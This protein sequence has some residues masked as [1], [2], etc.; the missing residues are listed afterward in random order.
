VRKS[1]QAKVAT[2]VRKKTGT[3]GKST[4]AKRRET[5][6]RKTEAKAAAPDI[7]K[8]PRAQTKP[9]PVFRSIKVP[10]DDHVGIVRQDQEVPEGLPRKYFLKS[11]F[12]TH[13]I[14]HAPVEKTVKMLDKILAGERLFTM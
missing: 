6:E 8:P 5:S 1:D 2:K 10:T 11:T 12:N 7:P 3:A 14:M 13:D 4:A 9:I